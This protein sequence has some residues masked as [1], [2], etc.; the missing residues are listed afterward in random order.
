VNYS[1]SKTIKEDLSNE[2][3]DAAY[4]EKLSEEQFSTLEDF[5]GLI[6]QNK[7]K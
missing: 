6:Y 3:F 5:R 2:D 7:K 1:S 4:K